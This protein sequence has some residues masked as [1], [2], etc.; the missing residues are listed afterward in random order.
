MLEMLF[1]ESCHRPIDSFGLRTVGRAPRA[2]SRPGT[3][4]RRGLSRSQDSNPRAT[5]HV[6]KKTITG[7]LV[8]RGK[9]PEKIVPTRRSIVSSTSDLLSHNAI[10]IHPAHQQIPPTIDLS[11]DPY[12]IRHE[13]EQRFE[14]IAAQTV[15]F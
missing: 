8:G 4:V 5:F 10:R 7:R 13:R 6:G 1:Q 12:G 3:P 14:R 15:A 2:H 9:P 11:L